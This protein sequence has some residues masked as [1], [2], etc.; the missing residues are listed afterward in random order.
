[1]K[2]FTSWAIPDVPDDVKNSIDRQAYLSRVLVENASPDE[3]DPEAVAMLP[4][5]LRAPELQIVSNSS[6]LA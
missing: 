3:D 1:M 4:R 2:Y 6:I 5:H